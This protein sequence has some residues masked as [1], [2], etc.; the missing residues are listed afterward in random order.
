M[1]IN[2]LD[3]RR[4]KEKVEILAGDR[5]AAGK[6]DRAV[7]LKE[8]GTS[9]GSATASGG[10]SGGGSAGNLGKPNGAAKLGPDGILLD[11]EVRDVMDDPGTYGDKTHLLRVTVD[12]K[13]RVTSISTIEIPDLDAI[14]ARLDAI[15]SVLPKPITTPTGIQLT[16]P[17]GSI[18]FTG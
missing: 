12:S 14:I 15:E 8:L 5:G 2:D 10:G 11:S 1:T 7:R 6:P 3:F 16:T 13:G 9:S 18:L 17:T 4:L